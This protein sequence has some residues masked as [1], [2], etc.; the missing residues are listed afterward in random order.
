MSGGKRRPPRR[1]YYPN[2]RFRQYNQGGGYN[3]SSD[4]DMNQ[5]GDS[6]VY[7]SASGSY[8]PPYGSSGGGGGGGYAP[9]RPFQHYGYQRPRSGGFRPNRERSWG[10]GYGGGGGGGRGYGRGRGRG[11][12]RRQD[13]NNPEA[14]YHLSMF[15]DPWRYLLPQEAKR[16]PAYVVGRTDTVRMASEERETK[17]DDGSRVSVSSR[18]DRTKNGGGGEEE[19]VEEGGAAMKDSSTET[20]GDGGGD[21][22]TETTKITEEVNSQQVQD[23]TLTT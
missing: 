19:V 12:Q 7:G 17:G 23:E 21:R 2:Q 1:P 16:P 14:Y 15:E 22:E 3:F 11:G 6:F 20:G 18:E 13:T 4:V 5:S 10:G 9:P 8:H